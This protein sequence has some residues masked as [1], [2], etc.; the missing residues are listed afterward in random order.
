MASSDPLSVLHEGL[1]QR[2]YAH[3]DGVV[4][5]D[6]AARALAEARAL[7]LCQGEVSSEAGYW[8]TETKVD[9]RG[10]MVAWLDEKAL[11]QQPAISGVVAALSRYVDGL[12]ARGLRRLV[13]TEERKGGRVVCERVMVA[14]YPGGDGRRFVPHL[15]NPNNNGRVLTFTYYLNEGYS[16]G[17]GGELSILASINGESVH[18]IQPLHNRSALMWSESVVHEVLPVVAPRWAVV[19]WFS[20]QSEDEKREAMRAIF[21]ALMGKTKKQ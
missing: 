12:R 4:S 19:V 3:V 6:V 20:L 21:A 17:D 8:R 5:D 2:G 18:K 1:D 10:D 16:E 11:A 7:D 15:D 13:E 9:R 14:H